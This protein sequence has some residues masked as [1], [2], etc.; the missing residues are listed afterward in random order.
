MMKQQEEDPFWRLMDLI[1]ENNSKDII[2]EAKNNQKKPDING[3]AE[4]AFLED[5]EK[6]EDEEEED[7]DNLSDDETQYWYDCVLCKM[8]FES[9]LARN[10]HML[11][12]DK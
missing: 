12:C 5:I 4:V 8:I 10:E 9:N 7:E 1:S 6:E 11:S 3:E 2:K